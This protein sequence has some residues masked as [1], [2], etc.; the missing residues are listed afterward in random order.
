MLRALVGILC[1][2]AVCTSLWADE[3]PKPTFDDFMGLNVHTVRFKPERYAGVVRHVRDYHG[4][5]WDV[6]E[7]TDT[8]TQ[9]PFAQN[10]VNWL[11]LYGAWKRAGFVPHVSVMFSRTPTDGWVDLPRDAYRYGKAFAS[12]FG[13]AHENLVP[14]V[15]IGNE[16]GHYEDAQY[17]ALLRA[18]GRG[19]R[20]GDRSMRIVTAAMR[21]GPSSRY[22][23]S[24]Q[25]LVGLERYYD[26]I[27]VHTYP[28]LE[29]WPT[30][31][32]SHPEDPNLDYLAKVQRVINWRDANAPGKAVW[33]TEFGYDASTQPAPEDGTFKQWEDVSDLAQA[34]YIV[35]SWLMFAAMDVQRAY[36]FFFEDADQPQVHGSSGI[37]RN[38]QPKPAFY[39]VRHLYRTLRRYHY[40]S[41]EVDRA[42]DVMAMRF[43]RD[44][45][46]DD[47]DLA[48]AILVV[49]RPRGD[50]LE[51]RAHLEYSPRQV[52]R[53]EKLAVDANGPQAVEIQSE[54]C[55][56]LS[57]PVDGSP[58]FIHLK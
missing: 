16:P 33:I 22:A 26:V 54:C 2:A 44:A 24:L 32:R 39:A 34:Q 31:K 19:I 48:S 43:M 56:T 55:G 9:F 27:A 57:L 17:A 58:I 12:Y 18:M 52:S 21:A 10:R 36:L 46:D 49:W 45:S 30:W 47:T 29:R 42:N 15:Q 51:R 35:R 28:M 40:E 20:A 53:A 1:L 8:P 3:F 4:F 14:S 25:S 23:K 7:R 38:D 13:P 41:T 5:N 6:G 50:H 11:K 37:Y